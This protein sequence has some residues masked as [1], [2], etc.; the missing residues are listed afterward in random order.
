MIQLW[1]AEQALGPTRRLPEQRPPPAPASQDFEHDGATYL[2]HVLFDADKKITVRISLREQHAIALNWPTTGFVFVPLLFSLPLLLIPAWFT[3]RAGLEPLRELVARI[4]DRVRTASLQPLRVSAF[5]ELS[6]LVQSVNQLLSR[7]RG[8][9]ARE[10]AFVA[11]VAHQLKTPLAIMQANIDLAR[12]PADDAQR[13][14]ALRDLDA[15]LAR[16][17]HLIRQLLRLARME[18]NDDNDDAA[19]REVDL[20]EFVRERVAMLVPLADRCRIGVEVDAPDRCKRRIDPDAIAAIVDNLLENAIRFSPDGGTIRVRLA[21]AARV[22]PTASATTP[23][24]TLEII[25]EGPGIAPSAMVGAFERFSRANATNGSTITTNGSA[26]GDSGTGLGLAI[27]RR[28]VERIHGSIE[29]L[30]ARA[31]DDSDSDSVRPPP[32]GAR[33]GTETAGNPGLRAIVRFPAVDE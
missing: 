3:I 23:S 30:P 15:G 5:R 11:D 18:H 26:M 29:L 25:D 9:L 27:V 12:A 10:R 20:A 13:Q 2:A 33:S 28:A 24:T 16:A 1:R 19:L 6:T 32:A 14:A 31:T 17:D 22:A 4:D 21:D 8:Q 7:L